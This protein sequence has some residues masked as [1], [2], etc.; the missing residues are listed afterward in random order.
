M[1]GSEWITARF[2]RRSD[3]NEKAVE[4]SLRGIDDSTDI[5]DGPSWLGKL[6]NKVYRLRS[7]IDFYFINFCF[8]PMMTFVVLLHRSPCARCVHFR[9]LSDTQNDGVTKYC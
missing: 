8:P 1:E 7:A 2:A 3:A 5:D 4:D 9:R 6:P